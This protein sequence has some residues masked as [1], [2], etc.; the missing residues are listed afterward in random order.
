VITALAVDK[1][2]LN[3]AKSPIPIIDAAPTVIVMAIS[4]GEK[5]P[6]IRLAMPNKYIHMMTISVSQKQE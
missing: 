6:L 3:R 1:R 5:W 4:I 2:D